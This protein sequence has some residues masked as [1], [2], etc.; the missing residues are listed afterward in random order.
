MTTRFPAAR[1]LV[2]LGVAATGLLGV[3]C[4]DDPGSI[5]SSYLPQNVIFK[6]YS[7]S[8]D[9]FT[10]TSGVSAATNASADGVTQ[11]LAGQA[12]DGT[13]ADGLIAFT[14]VPGV[15]DDGINRPVTKASFTLRAAGYLF[16]DTTSRRQ[17]A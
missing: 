14:S 16:G 5:G 8:S 10:V 4:N 7:L 17:S 9:E 1:L 13:I 2:V 3:G 12:S 11:I 6:T 15:L